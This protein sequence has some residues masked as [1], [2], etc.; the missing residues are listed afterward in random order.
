MVCSKERVLVGRR[1]GR[2][3]CDG[4]HMDMT[5]SV[6]RSAVQCSAVLTDNVEEQ[7]EEEEEVWT[8]LIFNSSW[9]GTRH[10]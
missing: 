8:T 2:G 4:R 7:E 10:A 9:P 3:R 1:R 6:Q 5:A